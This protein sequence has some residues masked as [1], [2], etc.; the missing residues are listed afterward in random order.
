MATEQ[1]QSAG[2]DLLST[3]NEGITKSAR[4]TKRPFQIFQSKIIRILPPLPTPFVQFPKIRWSQ[5]PIMGRGKYVYIQVIQRSQRP[6]RKTSPSHLLLTPPASSSGNLVSGPRLLQGRPSP[7][8]SGS[9]FLKKLRHLR[10]GR[11]SHQQQMP[12]SP[13]TEQINLRGKDDRKAEVSQ[14]TDRPTALL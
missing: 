14:E 4:A 2:K 9:G 8:R 12:I 13:N 1:L 7:S 5:G 11:C 6:E 3:A 10:D